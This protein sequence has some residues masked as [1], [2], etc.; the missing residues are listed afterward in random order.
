MKKTFPIAALLEKANW[1][2]EH[3]KDE[4]KEARE[5]IALFT[6]DILHQTGNYK[7]FG[8]LDLSKGTKGIYGPD[9][10]VFFY[11]A[12]HLKED[13]RKCSEAREK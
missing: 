11:V 5:S 7:G 3:S 13:Y 10:R 6:S 12:E 1:M 4:L 8:F 2:L 9:A